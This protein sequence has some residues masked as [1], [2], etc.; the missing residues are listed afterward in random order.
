MAKKRK[1]REQKLKADHRHFDYHFESTS[2]PISSKKVALPSTPQV[3]QTVND[4]LHPFLKHDLLKTVTVTSSMLIA[5][6]VI[7]SF[8]KI[9][10]LTFLGIKY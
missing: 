8:F 1:S 2:S 4:S 3:T 10:P 6:V 7:F 5:Q 9:H